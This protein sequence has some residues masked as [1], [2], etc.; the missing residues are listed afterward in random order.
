[1]FD[2]NFGLVLPSREY[3]QQ[4]PYLENGVFEI[5]NTI[6]LDLSGFDSDTDE[7]LPFFNSPQPINQIDGF[8]SDRATSSEDEIT[9]LESVTI[10]QEDVMETTALIE[11]G[12]S[13]DVKNETAISK[14]EYVEPDEISISSGNFLHH[15]C[16]RSECPHSQNRTDSDLVQ[17]PIVEIESVV[18]MS[19]PTQ[20]ENSA[21]SESSASNE[22]SLREKTH[23]Q[24]RL[25]LV[26]SKLTRDGEWTWNT[27]DLEDIQELN[28]N[29]WGRVYLSALKNGL[30]KMTYPAIKF[31]YVYN[32]I[33]GQLEAQKTGELS[34]ATEFNE[35]V[36]F[37]QTNIVS[38]PCLLCKLS[39]A[40]QVPNCYG[41]QNIAWL[42]ENNIKHCTLACIGKQGLLNLPAGPTDILNLGL[43]G[44]VTYNAGFD[45]TEIRSV[46]GTLHWELNERLE[47][48]SKASPHMTVVIE[49]FQSH[50]Q[51]YEQVPIEECLLG[52]FKVVLDL[53]ASYD[54][55]LIITLGPVMPYV[56]EQLDRYKALK[57]KANQFALFAKTL[58][59]VLGIPVI[60]TL[61]QTTYNADLGCYM[62]HRWWLNRPLFNRLGEPSEEFYRR[63]A[64]ELKVIAEE[65][66]KHL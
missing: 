43:L 46:K 32:E 17:E 62:S 60:Q 33:F 26:K 5:E 66:G 34:L 20:T 61:V 31:G 7:D 56:N 41:P 39:P 8:E 48:I 16:S 51:K 13:N 53:Q 4:N 50:E 15:T 64:T 29:P 45:D 35:D 30:T 37:D 27:K 36:E 59:K 42:T 12:E 11:S 52:F 2:F 47:K 44:S 49:F 23:L 54:G 10:N 9:V 58:G 14:P 18:S 19:N 24:N 25:V 57:E 65:R 3:E 28:L 22:L 55:A 40:K 21:Q 1:M 6:D 63:L 38:G